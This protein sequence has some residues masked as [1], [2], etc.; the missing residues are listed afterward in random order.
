[1]IRAFFNADGKGLAMSTLNGIEG[2]SALME[3]LRTA[4]GAAT[5]PLDRPTAATPFVPTSSNLAS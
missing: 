5:P 1:M 4:S 3:L 2:Y